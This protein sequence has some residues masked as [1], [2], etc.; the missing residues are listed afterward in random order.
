MR[1]QTNKHNP[2][3]PCKLSCKCLLTRLPHL[4][5]A[6]FYVSI[7]V[8]AVSL[9]ACPL[10]SQPSSIQ[11][12]DSVLVPQQL[13]EDVLNSIQ[14]AVSDTLLKPCKLI[15]FSKYDYHFL[16]R[17]QAQ[18]AGIDPAFTYED[19][20]FIIAQINQYEAE[21]RQAKQTPLRLMHLSI[22]DDETLKALG[23]THASFWAGF[24]KRFGYIAYIECSKP[25]FSKKM[26]YA[27]IE[28]DLKS[29]PASKFEKGVYVFKFEHSEWGFLKLL[30]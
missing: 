11:S 26:N 16:D 24:L 28:I 7:F 25:L 6:W 18:I 9:T 20:D 22:V 27:F 15:H 10:N 12:S 13:K 14:T 2:K 5:R 1:Q 19:Q 21:E 30:K 4:N 8:I 17:Y 29:N 3:P 23:K